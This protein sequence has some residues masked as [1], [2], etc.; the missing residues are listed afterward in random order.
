MWGRRDPTMPSPVPVTKCP[1][2]SGGSNTPSNPRPPSMSG[3][4]SS[5]NTSNAAALST[6]LTSAA[7]S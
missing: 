3:S 2:K 7:S 4:S 5:A 1:L 6:E